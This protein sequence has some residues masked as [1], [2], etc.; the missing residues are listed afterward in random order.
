MA[1]LFQSLGYAVAA[2][3]P[4]AGGLLLT[5]H[6]GQTVQYAYCL[7]TR[8][9]LS[10]GMVDRCCAFLAARG[11]APT[12]LVTRGRCSPESSVRA[13]SAG[14]ELVDGPQIRQWQQ[15]AA[16]LNRRRSGTLADTSDLS[17]KVTETN[18]G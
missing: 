16:W 7:R 15:Q 11:A 18:P 1:Q 8:Q 6:W 14:V 3:E 5:L 2:C 10:P 4:G 17:G 12:Y 9:A 13:R